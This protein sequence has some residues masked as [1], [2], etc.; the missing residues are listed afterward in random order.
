MYNLLYLANKKKFK[1]NI[2][3]YRTK[4][5]LF[6]TFLQC[7]GYTEGDLHNIKTDADIENSLD[8]KNLKNINTSQKGKFLLI[9]NKQFSANDSNKDS[10][11]FPI[12]NSEIIR[13]ENIYNSPESKNISSSI[14]DKKFE[15]FSNYSNFSNLSPHELEYRL[16][17]GDEKLDPSKQIQAQILLKSS[18]NTQ[19]NPNLKQDIKLEPVLNYKP[20]TSTSTSRSIILNNF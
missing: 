20:N 1:L 13:E 6:L 2:T 8:I 19:K 4:K 18:S 7:K 12:E 11:N 3:K 16:E 5:N 9:N 15:N 14:L 10:S 17:N